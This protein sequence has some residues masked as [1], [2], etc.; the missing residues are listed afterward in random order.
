MDWAEPT[1]ADDDDGL[2]AA[3]TKLEIAVAEIDR[4]REAGVRF[5]C[6]L[7][8]AGYGSA[9]FRQALSARRLSWAVGIS[10]RNKVYPADVTMIFPVAGRGGGGRASVM[11]R[12]R[13]RSRRRRSW[14]T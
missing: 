3:R 9:P 2:R 7:A 5:G 13:S 10:G 8:D 11:C 6:V 1:R 4:V 14:Q 12:I